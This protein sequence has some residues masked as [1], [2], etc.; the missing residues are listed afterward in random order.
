MAQGSKH[1]TIKYERVEEL[2]FMWL[3]L[4]TEENAFLTKAFFIYPNYR[5]F[6][7]VGQTV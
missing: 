1:V 4:S 5:R 2:L 6:Y 7:S 3:W